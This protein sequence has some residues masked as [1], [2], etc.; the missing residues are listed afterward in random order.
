MPRQRA[1]NRIP[2][3]NERGLPSTAR[4]GGFW[5]EVYWKEIERSTGKNSPGMR[6]DCQT[7]EEG[8]MVE[9][10]AQ[11]EKEISGSSDDDVKAALIQ[12]FV[13]SHFTI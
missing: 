5:K 3:G 6:T 11:C 8:E 12:Q 10:R 2:R 7:R 1:G 9:L 4:S 13:F